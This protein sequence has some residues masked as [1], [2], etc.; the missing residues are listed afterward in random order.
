VPLS[1]LGRFA[2]DVPFW[3]RIDSRVQGPAVTPDPED[4]STFTLR[5]LIT[6]LSRRRDAQDRG[7]VV[8]AG[9]FRLT[10]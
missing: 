8:D 9:P 4:D 1:A 6:V 10:P 5:R 7:R 2:R 3:V